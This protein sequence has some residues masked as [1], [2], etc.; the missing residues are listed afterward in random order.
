MSVRTDDKR[1]YV[2]Y[3]NWASGK[4]TF[5]KNILSILPDYKYVCIDDIRF[6]FYNKYRQM[7]SM[8]RER[9]CEEECLIQITNA[10]FLIFETTAATL[11]FN[12]IKSRIKVY[13]N[14]SFIHI[15]CGVPDCHQRFVMRNSAANR[16]IA[17]P[18]K[19]K[20]S[21]REIMAH[22]EDQHYNITPDLVLD[23]V[24]STPEE[25]LASFKSFIKAKTCTHN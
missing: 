20:M 15:K 4:T 2:I 9:K 24:N 13:F 12:R 21:I 3:G 22:V 6:D 14:T 18:F 1:C 25:M 19:N 23:S 10:R 16:Q 8:E 5:V 7:N 11:F 17:P